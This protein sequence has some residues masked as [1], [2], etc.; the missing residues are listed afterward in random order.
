[1]SGTAQVFLKHVSN[2]TNPGDTPH[3]LK[4]TSDGFLEIRAVD[5][6]SLWKD[7]PSHNDVTQ[8]VL[9]DTG[10]AYLT[11]DALSENIWPLYLNDLG[12]RLQ[13]GASL[14]SGQHITS[15]NRRYTFVLQ[16]NDNLVLY[17]LV[18]SSRPVWAS[19]TWHRG[20]KRLVLQEDGD[21]VLNDS[22]DVARW[23]SGTKV[24]H[25]GKTDRVLEIRD[26]GEV[27]LLDRDEAKV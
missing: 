6:T 11:S 19:N 20:T 7:G 5:G 13:T 24:E 15:A 26:N 22:K 18:P 14:Y 1:M 23:R 25:E 8:F 10:S 27:V 4:L 2:L 3:E 17:N 16:N 12:Q 9:T 21:L